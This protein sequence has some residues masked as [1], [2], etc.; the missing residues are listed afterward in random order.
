MIDINY[1]KRKNSEL[2]KSLEEPDSLFLSKTQNYIPIY[3][4][5][6]TLNDTNYN[7]VNLNHKWYISSVNK[8]NE[9][10]KNLYN[11]RIK[12]INN[13]IIVC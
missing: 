4:K 6:F 1:Q 3:N 13:R 8:S 5:F 2:F 10:N 9:D 12:N 7:N 11:C